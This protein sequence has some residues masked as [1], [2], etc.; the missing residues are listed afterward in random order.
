[1][2]QAEEI[3]PSCHQTKHETESSQ[4]TKECGCDQS[5]AI[6]KKDVSLQDTLVAAATFVIEQ[7]THSQMT[8]SSFVIAYQAPPQ[9]YDVTPLYIKHAILR[10]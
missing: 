2:A 6:I 1:M 8:V 10:I 4:N 5:L 3:T 9:F 7:S